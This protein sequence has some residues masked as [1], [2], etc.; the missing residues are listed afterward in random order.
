MTLL[1]D[2]RTLIIPGVKMASMS[3][4]AFFASKFDVTFT[5]VATCVFCF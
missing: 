2:L 1:V 3:S 4:K 5:T